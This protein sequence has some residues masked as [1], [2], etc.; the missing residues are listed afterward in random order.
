MMTANLN[1]KNPPAID[2]F[3][4]QPTYSQRLAKARGVLETAPKRRELV[5]VQHAALY[6]DHARVY[7][8][9]NDLRARH[10]KISYADIAAHVLE[11][12][13]SEKV[14][15]ITLFAY[16]EENLNAV[17]QSYLEAGKEVTYI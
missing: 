11:V 6:A 13:H 10:C 2:S 8:F 14:S 7:H 15:D 3:A 16:I 4:L 12:Y 17:C 5:T 9:E 1:K